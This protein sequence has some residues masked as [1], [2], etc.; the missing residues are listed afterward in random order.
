MMFIGRKDGELENLFLLQTIKKVDEN[1]AHLIRFI[2]T[3][4]EVSDEAFESAEARD[5]AYT[6]YKTSMLK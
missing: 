2:H 3:N 5:A 4:G 1:E 6:E